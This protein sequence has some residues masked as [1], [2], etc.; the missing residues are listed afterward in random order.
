[1]LRAMGFKGKYEEGLNFEV[2]K[3]CLIVSPELQINSPKETRLP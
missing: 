1:M 2:L 3:R